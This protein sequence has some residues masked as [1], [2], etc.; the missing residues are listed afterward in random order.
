RRALVLPGSAAV[1]GA[2]KIAAQRVL[3]EAEIIEPPGSVAGEDRVA[4][5]N[6]GFQHA[7][8]QPGRTAIGGITPPGL[9]KI[10]GYAVELTPTNRDAPGI[11]RVEAQ[12]RFVGGVAHNILPGRVDVNLVTGA[13]LGADS[14]PGAERGSQIGGRGVSDFFQRGSSVA[15]ECGGQE[16]RSQRDECATA[17]NHRYRKSSFRQ[18]SKRQAGS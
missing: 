10:V 17:K 16:G 6:V 12:R 9:P 4:S 3:L 5:K 2:P 15:A 14:G 1:G 13:E 11:E 7:T 8:V 18:E